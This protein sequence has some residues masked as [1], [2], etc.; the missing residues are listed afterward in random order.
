MI[1]VPLALSV[2]DVD[3]VTDLS[4]TV[5]FAAVALLLDL[6]KTPLGGSSPCGDPCDLSMIPTINALDRWVTENDSP[7]AAFASDLVLGALV[8][9]PLIGLAGDPKDTLVGYQAIFATMLAT[10]LMKLSIKRPRPLAYNPSFVAE[11]RLAGDARLSFPSGH[12]SLAFAS[13]TA[14][15]VPW[16]DRHHGLSGFAGA[17]SAYAIASIVAALRVEAGR[18]FVTDVLVGAAL[19]IAVGVVVTGLH[20]GQDMDVR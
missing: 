18:H 9:S 2:F 4:A 14:F 17:A 8:L 15:A 10:N 3:L 5:S 7:D 19:G 11:I 1:A 12:T 13:A 6:E 20:R 16:I